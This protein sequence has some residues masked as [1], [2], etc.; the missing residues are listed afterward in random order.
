MHHFTIA[1]VKV[2]TARRSAQTAARFQSTAARVCR[3]LPVWMALAVARLDRCLFV[4]VRRFKRPVIR[5]VLAES[6]GF[7]TPREITCLQQ[8]TQ[9]LPSK[10]NVQ[11]KVKKV[12]IPKN[13][14]KFLSGINKL[15]FKIV[16]TS[17]S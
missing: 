6:N 11:T 17:Q 3:K 7:R 9:L 13:P 12:K 10:Y 16:C 2:T 1:R 4:S 8:K 14:L 5:G 15:F